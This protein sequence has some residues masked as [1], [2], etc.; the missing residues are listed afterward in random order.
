MGDN[1]PATSSHTPPSHTEAAPWHSERGETVAKTSF[2]ESVLLG[3]TPRPAPHAILTRLE[4]QADGVTHSKDSSLLTRLIHALFML[5]AVKLGFPSC[6]LTYRIVLAACFP[7]KGVGT[8][9]VVLLLCL[10]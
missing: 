6:W 7:T 4:A 8:V 1:S 10:R 9:W 3:S 2:G 5:I